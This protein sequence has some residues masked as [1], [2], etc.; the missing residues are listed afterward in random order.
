VK[1]SNEAPEE[2][3]ERKGSSLTLPRPDINKDLRFVGPEPVHINIAEPELQ[4]PDP[5]VKPKKVVKK[6]GRW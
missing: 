6:K 5:P 3:K 1:K 2:A 4:N